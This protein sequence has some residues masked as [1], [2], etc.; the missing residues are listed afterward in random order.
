M[1]SVLTIKRNVNVPPAQVYRAFIHATA[2]RDWLCNAAQAEARKGGRLYLWWNSSVYASGVYTKLEPGKKVAWVWH[3][4]REP[5]NAQITVSFAPKTGGGTV[6]TLKHAV[7]SGAKWKTIIPA[8]QAA[9]ESALE[10]LQSVL[11]TGVDL[12]EARLPRLGIAIGD[13]NAEIAARL[14]VPVTEGIR[15]EG[16]V[17]GTGARA[18]GLQKDDVIIRLGG[19]K[20]VDFPSLQNVLEEHQA[21][22]KVKVVFYRG[23]EKKTVTMALS[24][25]TTPELPATAAGLADLVRKNYAD[26]NLDLARLFQGMSEPEAEHHPTLDAWSIKELV[27]HFIAC[28]RDFQSWVADMLNDNVAG[29]SLEFRPNVTERLRVM[30]ERFG[31]LPALME[32]LNRSQ[33]ETAALLA[34]LPDA[35]V[36]RKHLYRRVAG[37]MILYVPVHYRE[38]HWD[39]MQTVIQSARNAQ[40]SLPRDSADLLARIQSEWAALNQAIAGLNDEQMNTPD[41]GGW[42]VKDNLAHLAA[43]EQFMLQHYLQ[44]HPAHEA[45]QVDEATWKTLDEIGINAILHERNQA[46]LVSDVLADRRRSHEQVVAALERMPFADL[47]KPLYP[48]DP[49]ARPLIGWVIGNTY[50]H[51]QEHRTTIEAWIKKSQT[52]ALSDTGL[53]KAIQ[54]GDLPQVTALLDRDARL[55]NARDEN[56]LSAVLFATYHGQPAIAQLLVA[57]GAR[58]SIFEA[59]AVGQLDR[60]NELV[61]TQPDLVNAYAEDGF[62]PLGLAS[63]FGHANV[64]EFLLDHGA[65]VNSPSRNAQQVMPLHSA[66]AGQHLAIVQALLAHGANPNARQA[67]DFTPLHAAAQNGQIEM[68]ELLLAHGADANAKAN[69]KTPLAFAIEQKHQATTDSLRQHGGSL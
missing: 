57:R 69:G 12:R 4:S 65:E 14:D 31:T 50:E 21:G 32:E 7:G 15:L 67:E 28:E 66:A 59:S 9:W 60:V 34:V 47:I 25:R 61:K 30:V 8:A 26:I 39:Q 19:K 13:F 55:V 41:A 29:D 3:H 11:E 40:A 6:V 64:A 2:L 23:A 53:F 27:A 1:A 16:T 22:D 18:A 38:E 68:V 37:W 43:W 49:K 62:Q 5:E 56:G 45:M 20:S 46:R 51:Y 33:A 58:L 48:D 44:R 36:A 10:N 63:F 42:S 24:A 17:E 35:F 52:G 54:T